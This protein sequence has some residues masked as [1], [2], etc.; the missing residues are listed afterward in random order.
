VLPTGRRLQELAQEIGFD[1]LSLEKV[2]R[3]AELLEGVA[4]LDDL[5]ALLALKGG[6]ALNL[7]FGPPSRLSVDLDFNLVGVESRE[8]LLAIRPEVEHRLQA[9]ARSQGFGVQ[10]SAEA[11]A[12]RKFFLTYSRIVDSQPDRIEVDLNYLHRVC[13]V[14]ADR[15]A[16]WRPDAAGPVTTVLSWP[17]IAAG[18]LVASLDRAAPR[19]SWDVSRLPALSPTPW[20]PRDLRP[21]FVALAGALPRPLH[22]YGRR[23]LERIRDTDVS[24]LLWPMLLSGERPAADSLR[25]ACWSIVSPLLD[26]DESEIEFCDRLQRGELAPELLAFEDPAIGE[27]VRRHP[28]LLWKAENAREH[29][30]RKE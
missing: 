8:E 20:P 1:V 29:A 24:R 12:G 15:R 19:D 4:G 30:R 6:T 21:I 5:A 25:D 13:L 26:L 11:H 18:K 9:L 27:R 2:V 16:I 7:A 22:P 23:G 14:P 28:A 3:L 17:E 10:R